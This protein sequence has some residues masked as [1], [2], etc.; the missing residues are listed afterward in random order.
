MTVE[1]GIIIAALLAISEV[2]ALIPSIGS[3]SIFQLIVNI[4]RSLAPKVRRILGFE[5]NLKDEKKKEEP[6]KK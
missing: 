1:F 6:K 4:L 3:N 5:P 2:L